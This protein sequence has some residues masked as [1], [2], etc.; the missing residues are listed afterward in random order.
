MTAY[1]NSVTCD[2][3]FV[4][5]KRVSLAGPH[6]AYMREG[7]K[8]KYFNDLIV[9]GEDCREPQI[10][11][12]E[13]IRK[14]KLPEGAVVSTAADELNIDEAFL[15]RGIHPVGAEYNSHDEACS[16]RGIH[17]V[18]AEHNKYARKYARKGNNLV[19]ATALRVPDNRWL[20]G[21]K[22]KDG[23]YP[24]LVVEYGK[25]VGE[26]RAAPGGWLVVT[27]FDV[28]GIPVKVADMKYPHPMFYIHWGINPEPKRDNRTGEYDVA[29]S[30]CSGSWV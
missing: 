6:A 14:G 24:R 29:P 19:T 7:G 13:M 16:R 28:F 21:R 18:D 15:R 25:V 1:Q 10:I 5:D 23:T 3:E 30:C 9:T 22:D 27:E 26:T 12:D 17:P 20:K 8:I 11:F 2:K 4:V